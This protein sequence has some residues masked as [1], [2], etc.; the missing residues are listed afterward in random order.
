MVWL[1]GAIK[2]PP[3]DKED[4]LEAGYLLRRLQAGLQVLMPHSRPMPS[5]GQRC[6]E[7]R[8]NDKMSTWRI[9]YRIDADVI[10]ILE[11]FQKKV[12]KTPQSVFETSRRRA[13]KYAADSR[14]ED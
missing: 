4:R 3:L 2:T 5:V 14:G 13:R 8:I 10:L 12:E 9:V 1:G 6:H 7:L 11:V